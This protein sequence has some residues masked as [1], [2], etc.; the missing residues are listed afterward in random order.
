MRALLLLLLPIATAF[1][2]T[3]PGRTALTDAAGPAVTPTLAKAI[4]LATGSEPVA[5][6][7]VVLNVGRSEATAGV[8]G[9]WGASGARLP[10]KVEVDFSTA[11]A[12]A[13][14]A[15]DGEMAAAPRSSTVSF[16]DFVDEARQVTASKVF[17]VHEGG[18]RLD[19]DRDLVVWLRF[20]ET[21][22]RGDVSVPAGRL[23][24]SAKW[25]TS[26]ELYEL[27]QTYYA[28]REAL[29]KAAEAVRDV[30][31]ADERPKVWNAAAEAWERPASTDSAASGAKKRIEK[32][33]AERAA[34][35]A[36]ALRPD[37]KALSSAEGA[38]PEFGGGCWIERG[39]SITTQP[40]GGG[41]LVALL[42]GSQTLGSWAAE[43]VI[44]GGAPSYY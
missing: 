9:A 42:R 16:T 28:A 11:P 43:P 30:D 1:S 34:E 29:W 15:A 32:V 41:P 19:N 7:R 27:D 39:G 37:T 5:T 40:P 38:W 2:W 21:M 44:E 18:W 35:A 3:V 20:P 17:P 4:A 8:S 24:F 10:L 33:A 22:A 23:Y 13:Q 26:A 6:W 25:W 36:A 14:G 31:R 12:T